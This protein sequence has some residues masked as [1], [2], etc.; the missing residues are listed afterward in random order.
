MNNLH[1]QALKILPLAVGASIIALVSTRIG[2]EKIF[3]LIA[4]ANPVLIA[5]AIAFFTTGLLLKAFVFNQLVNK[6]VQGIAFAEV[7]Y[8]YLIGQITNELLPTGS[9]ELVKIVVLEKKYKISAGKSSAIMIVQR[10]LDLIAL[11][12]TA[13]IGAFL[14]GFY[15]GDVVRAIG[16]A[17]AAVIATVFVLTNTRLIKLGFA[18]AEKIP[19]V[20]N[21]IAGLHADF[22]EAV[23]KLVR[24]G[25]L[26]RVLLMMALTLAAWFF[27]V[28][29]QYMLLQ[30]FNQQPEIFLIALVT[31]ISWIAGTFSFLPG[32]IGAREFVFASLLSTLGF[33]FD[34]AFSA[35]L[36]YRFLVYAVFGT[37]AFIG[38]YKITL[39]ESK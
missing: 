3:E 16:I 17:L 8:V 39:G 1:K 19:I 27:E 29:T 4:S 31:S 11:L 23:N 24:Q 5:L 37:G 21:K 9:G 30:A 26:R 34:A 2:V 20:K 10:L 38:T 35:A 13:A 14:L 18:V 15:Q 25:G 6:L 7:L 36:L 33:S 12:L 22:E 28:L 32:G